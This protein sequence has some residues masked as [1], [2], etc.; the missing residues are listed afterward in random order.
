MNQ[1][2]IKNITYLA[3]YI[4]IYVVKK[5]KSSG[6]HVHNYTYMSMFVPWKVYCS[7]LYC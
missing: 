3:R 4:Y 2:M 1:S 6:N 5:G 7:L